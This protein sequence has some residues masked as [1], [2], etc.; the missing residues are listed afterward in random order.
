MK[1][2]TPSFCANHRDG[3]AHAVRALNERPPTIG[4]NENVKLG[5]RLVSVIAGNQGEAVSTM[6]KKKRKKKKSIPLEIDYHAAARLAY[7]AWLDE[8]PDE[9]ASPDA[10]EEFQELYEASA[11]ALATAKKRERDLQAFDNTPA[12]PIPP[13]KIT[14]KKVQATTTSS[15]GDFFFASE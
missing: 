6:Q 4:Y 3:G 2:V 15:T 11:V 12:K 8:H 9:K 7:Q 10:Y 14:T 13:R 1:V 5:F